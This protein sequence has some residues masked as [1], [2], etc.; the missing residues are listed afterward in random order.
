MSLHL[1]LRGVLWWPRQHSTCRSESRHRC[2][3][4]QGGSTRN[5][6]HFILV[7]LTAPPPS[8]VP[9]AASAAAASSPASPECS[10]L[11]MPLSSRDS[12]VRR[13]CGVRQGFSSSSGEP[14]VARGPDVAKLAVS[15][16]P[17]ADYRRR[18]YSRNRRTT[19]QPLSGEENAPATRFQSHSGRTKGLFAS[20]D[21]KCNINS[22]QL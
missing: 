22:Q 20:F 17:S 6:A 3:T 10:A 18:Q 8:S 16:S 12:V 4:S 19:I 9:S 2:R 13:S 14:S 1:G 7:L 15:S 5:V 11:L 21:E